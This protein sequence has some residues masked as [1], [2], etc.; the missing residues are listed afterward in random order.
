LT[1]CEA[2]LLKDTEIL[3]KL[4]DDRNVMQLQSDNLSEK[5][6]EIKNGIDQIKSSKAGV[7]PEDLIELSKQHTQLI[8]DRAKI[9]NE[10]KEFTNKIIVRNKGLKFTED[11]IKRLNIQLGSLYG[12]LDKLIDIKRQLREKYMDGFS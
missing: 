7:R 3:L 10:T 8:N 4:E 12:N 11:K 1:P 5:I 6:T 9:Q 2:E